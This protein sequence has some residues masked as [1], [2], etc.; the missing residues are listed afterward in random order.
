MRHRH[1]DQDTL[2][3]VPASVRLVAI[4][5][6]LRWCRAFVCAVRIG[7]PWVCRRPWDSQ[8][9]DNVVAHSFSV[10]QL[11][12]ALQGAALTFL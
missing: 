1:F 5:A 8:S 12:L 3:D 4:L 2:P 11:A 9:A 7:D 6:V 10:R